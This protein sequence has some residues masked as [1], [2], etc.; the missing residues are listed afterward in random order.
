MIL[1]FFENGFYFFVDDDGGRDY[2]HG[3]KAF[4]CFGEVD[5]VAEVRG[6]EVNLA[7][8]L[9]GGNGEA[10][11]VFVGVTFGE[12]GGALEGVEAV[13]DNVGLV[14]V[15]IKSDGLPYLI[16]WLGFGEDDTA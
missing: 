6:A 15:G 13:G 5:Q 16:T 1:D 12:E 11:G 10:I 7:N 9:A 8:D 3:D 4:G 14:G 2:N